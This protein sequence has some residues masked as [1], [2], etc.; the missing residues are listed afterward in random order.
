MR[1]NAVPPE[2]AAKAIKAKALARKNRSSEN[3]YAL[4]G[5]LSSIVVLVGVLL[6]LPA[7]FDQ[8]KN[9]LIPILMIIGTSLGLVLRQV[10]PPEHSPRCPSC[11]LDWT[12]R[13]GRTVPLSQ[14]M[15][16]WDKCP[17]CDGIMNDGLLRLALNRVTQDNKTLR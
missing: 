15:L 5:F 11:G 3:L 7:I 1:W 10:N 12:I 6:F 13:E 4:W 2:Y 8:T 16:T 17:G 14:Q 9:W